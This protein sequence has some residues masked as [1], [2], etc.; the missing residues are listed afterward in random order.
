MSV[1]LAQNLDQPRFVLKI[2]MTHA[3]SLT[4]DAT[5][6]YTMSRTRLGHSE[7]I[8]I[9]NSDDILSKIRALSHGTHGTT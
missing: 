4:A 6:V 5:A 9:M 2:V 7:R 8:Y 3:V 1:D